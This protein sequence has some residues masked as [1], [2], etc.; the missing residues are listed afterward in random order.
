MNGDLKVANGAANLSAGAESGRAPGKPRAIF[1][2]AGAGWAAGRLASVYLPPQRARLETLVSLHPQELVPDDL[3]R[4]E[5]A[6]V[7]R[8][9][10]F[11]FSTWGMPK[12]DTETLARFENLECV[13]YAAGSV[14]G[15][16]GPLLARGVKVVSAWGANAVPVAEFTLAQTLLSLKGA[17]RQ[18]MDLKRVKGPAAW[19]RQ[20]APGAFG[21]TVALV[22]LGMIGRRVAELLKPF[23][24]HVIAYEPYARSG[25]AQSL[26]VELVSLEECF[27]RGDVVSLHA[28]NL[29]A[30]KKMITGALLRQMKPGAT[31]IN[32]AR[33]AIVDNEAMFEVLR[34][35]PDLTALIDV[36]D[37]TEPPP[38]G[39]PYY[40][41]PNLILTPHIAGSGGQ[42]LARMGDYVIDECARLLRGEPLQ[43]AVT[44]SM[45]AT[46]A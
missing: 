45:L 19:A 1:V 29:P 27:R 13:F 34:E 6:E 43:W 42:E 38:A 14:Q 33:A 21:S 24:V 46:M 40:E 9:A 4:P 44:E 28:P 20:G 37:P 41:L 5:Y 17:W 7:V 36:A 25:M 8:G 12:L 15:F 30:T 39:S 18:A 3:K 35:R 11:I 23:D 26:G 2:R 31:F 16:A 10:R 22:S 32:T